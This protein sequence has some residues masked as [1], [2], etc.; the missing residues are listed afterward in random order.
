MKH[1]VSYNHNQRGVMADHVG[2][3]QITMPLEII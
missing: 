2:F 1:H 3:V